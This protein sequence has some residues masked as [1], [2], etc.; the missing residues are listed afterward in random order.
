[1]PLVSYA[2][3]NAY[4]NQWHSFL[5]TPG[6][7]VLSFGFRLSLS[8][9][10]FV[11]CHLSLSI[12]L[13]TSILKNATKFLSSPGLRI[14]SFGFR[15]TW[16]VQCFNKLRRFGGWGLWNGIAIFIIIFSSPWEQFHQHFFETF[17]HS[18]TLP[19]NC[20]LMGKVFLR[21]SSQNCFNFFSPHFATKTNV[22]VS[23]EHTAPSLCQINLYP[24]YLDRFQWK[25]ERIVGAGLSNLLTHLYTVQFREQILN[26]WK[27][28]ENTHAMNASSSKSILCW[29]AWKTTT[30]RFL[31]LVTWE[32]SRRLGIRARSITS[33]TAKKKRQSGNK[34]KRQEA[35]KQAKQKTNHKQKTKKRGR[36]FSSA[37]YM[38]REQESWQKGKVNY[39][40]R[41]SKTA[42]NQ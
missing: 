22:R 27:P 25:T 35:R 42:N 31:L 17:T 7:R 39:G 4:S 15:F 23:K 30:T 29:C 9:F 36:Q 37:S 19:Q 10:V 18:L 5:S 2:N 8:F 6:L 41:T 14:L 24:A 34:E 21:H 13:L 32:E 1:M 3:A 33:K 26:M 38:R 11:F 40:K 28:K 16:T 20:L 12:S